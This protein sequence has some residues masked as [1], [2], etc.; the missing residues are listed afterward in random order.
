MAK[1]PHGF[2]APLKSK[3]FVRLYSVYF[4][5]F[6]ATSI[7]EA[8][9]SWD[10]AAQGAAPSIVALASTAA[11]LPI[12]LMIVPFGALADMGL[13]INLVRQSQIATII[14]AC[15]L[16]LLALF[17]LTTPAWVLLA[18]GFSGAAMAMRLPA[19]TSLVPLSLEKE[20]LP[21]G[22]ALLGVAT[23]LTRFVGPALA[24]VLILLIGSSASYAF[25]AVCAAVALTATNRMSPPASNQTAL[26]A[27]RLLGALRVASGFVRQSPDFRTL[28]LR[29]GLFFFVG[30]AAQ[31][32]APLAAT[33]SLDGTSVLY[34]GMIGATGIGALLG[35]WILPSL[36]KHLRRTSVARLGLVHMGLGGLLTAFAPNVPIALI[37]AV[38]H[39]LGWL[40]GLATFTSLAQQSLPNWVRAR[41]MALTHAALIAGVAIGAFF[42]GQLSVFVSL[43]WVLS[44]AALCTFIMAFA[45]SWLTLVSP[46]ERELQPRRYWSE[47]VLAIEVEPDEGPAVI[48][49]DYYIQEG[50]TESFLQALQESRRLRL[51]N[52]AISWLLYRD[53]ENPQ[54]FVEQIMYESWSERLRQTHR[55]TEADLFIRDQKLSL[56]EGGA[57]PS[58]N[59]LV[60]VEV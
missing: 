46:Q 21:D 6:V 41:G 58:V 11:T 48:L 44:L 37:G 13:H 19:L 43:Q 10:L 26:P 18:I 36:R 50:A 52:G 16:T 7:L 5:C 39:G 15:A 51:R 22:M 4:L 45:P 53:V 55:T 25:V 2:L 54:H 47:P 60:S 17:G 33:R 30:S 12:V 27:E 42:W 20:E 23:S 34:M 32:L 31:A 9:A 8:S 14:V 56:L 1:F 35:G 28:L 57:V 29:G 49:V 40:W 59:H 3:D 24:A 38:L